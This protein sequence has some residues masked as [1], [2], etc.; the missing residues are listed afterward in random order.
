MTNERDHIQPARTAAILTILRDSRR[1][2]TA[3]CFPRDQDAAAQPGLYTWWADQ[4]GIRILST[5]LR[6]TLPPLIYLGQ[7]GAAPSSTTLY[8]RVARCHI[9]GS[10]SNSTFRRT[11]AAVLREPLGLVVVGR[12][13]LD[14]PSEE[15]LSLWIRRHLTVVI[16]P[17]RDRGALKALEHNLLTQLDPPLNLNGMPPNAVRRRLQMLRKALG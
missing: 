4:E 1:A 14:Q 9:A 3:D 13:K 16:A 7:A 12:M 2:E 5:P 6:T 17:Y 15:R 8:L 11:L 10:L